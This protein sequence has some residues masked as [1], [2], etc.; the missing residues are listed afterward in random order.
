MAQRTDQRAPTRVELDAYNKALKLSDH[1]M[2]VCKPKEKNVNTHHIP[3][4]N[5]GLGRMLMEA[6]VELGADIL[7][8]NMRSVGPN[9]SAEKRLKN[10]GD[11]F[12]L[13][14]HALRMTYRLE[15][16]FRILHFDRPFA[17]ST[18]SYMMELLTETR[19]LLVKWRDADEKQSKQLTK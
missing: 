9:A 17:E 8:A 19:E 1:V 2:S 3:K 12:D 10:Y 15:H 5:A 14:E 18:S 6:A 7:D 13:Q 11:R 4:R 16:I